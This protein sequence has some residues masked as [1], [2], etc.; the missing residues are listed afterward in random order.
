[1]EEI[2]PADAPRDLLPYIPAPVIGLLLKSWAAALGQP[3]FVT[4]TVEEITGAPARRFAQ[5][6]ADYA[7]A[8][9]A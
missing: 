5:W 9:R 7:S 6:A 3:A 1:M 4:S 2:A 8:F